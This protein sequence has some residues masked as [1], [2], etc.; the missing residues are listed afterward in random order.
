MRAL[1]AIIVFVFGS[2]LASAQVI[3]SSIRVRVEAATPCPANWTR[4]SATTVA[5][6]SVFYSCAVVNRWPFVFGYL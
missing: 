3:Y 4:T 2:A 6:G 5:P 1:L